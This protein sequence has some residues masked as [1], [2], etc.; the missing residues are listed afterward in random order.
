MN[1]GSVHEDEYEPEALSILAR[2]AESGFHLAE[3]SEDIHPYATGIVAEVMKFWFNSA[4]EDDSQFLAKWS[5]LAARLVEI[6]LAAW[7]LNDQKNG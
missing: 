4:V 3:D 5:S 7:P 2:F 6:Y 1:L